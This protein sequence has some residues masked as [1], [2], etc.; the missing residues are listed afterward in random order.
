M[1]NFAEWLLEAEQT[2]RDRLDSAVRE[3]MSTRPE[4]RRCYY[5]TRPKNMNFD[6]KNPKHIEDELGPDYDRSL[7]VVPF[8]H[9]PMSFTCASAAEGLVKFLREKGF[10]ARKVSGWYGHAEDGYSAGYDIRLD[11]PTPPRSYG[12]TNPQQHWWVE[13]EGMYIDITSAQFHPTRP[14][15]QKDLVIRDK[16]DAFASGDYAPV[17]RFPLGRSVR[18]PPNIQKMVDKILS[19]KKFATGHSSKPG[20]AYE[21][22]EWIKRNSKR[23]GLSESRLHDIVAALAAQTNP[24]FHFSDKRGLERLFG[25]GF[26]D[27]DEDPELHS[28]PN[29]FKPP[30]TTSRG[31]VRIGRSNFDG[32]SRISLT[33]VAPDELEDNLEVLKGLIA[34]ASP[35]T[36][37]SKSEK[38]SYAAARGGTVYRISV[39]ASPAVQWSPELDAEMKREKFRYD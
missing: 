31:T 34:K 2:T 37:F 23:Y 35:D 36:K 4:A 17:R 22:S 27:L 25:E 15:N 30:R 13:A 6:P 16:H 24:G 20:D 26:D 5:I 11:D 8:K 38:D 9:H 12:M 3:Y 10:N 28:E 1:V 18:L 32:D 29:D 21:L 7:D 19:L 39:T 33:S 14:N